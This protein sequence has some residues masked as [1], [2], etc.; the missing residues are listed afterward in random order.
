MATERPRT[1]ALFPGQASQTPGMRDAVAAERPELLDAA[2]RITGDDP[3]ERV[4]DGTQFAQPAIFCASVTAWS[5]LDGDRPDV[6][7]GHSLGEFAALVA[8]GALDA[9]DG[10]KLVALRGRLMAEAA[11]SERAG[12]MLAVLGA[13]VEV[14]TEIAA[15]HGVIV[16]NDNAPG[17]IVLSGEARALERAADEARERGHKAMPL[18]VAGAFHSPAMAPVVPAFRAA[19]DEVEF[20]PPHTPVVSSITAE[21]FD[22]VRARLAEALTR[23]VRWRETLL[24]LREQGVRSFVEVG[25]GK[26][27]T[28]LV[29]RTLEGVESRAA[30]PME[31]SGA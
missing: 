17:Q 8:A 12:G 2:M 26:V 1:A 22:D 27:L 13:G 9:D 15:R 19:L 5:S 23:P 29:K 4:N 30:R 10:L 7:A 28:G 3:F 6:V 16:A 14:V 11:D 20:A 24:R 18:R 21:P 25:P 31:G